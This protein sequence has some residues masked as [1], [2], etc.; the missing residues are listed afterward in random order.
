MSVK[1]SRPNFAGSI[2]VARSNF[3]PSMRP[4]VRARVDELGVLIKRDR[5]R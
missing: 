2:P 4:L 5:Q 1:S 3:L